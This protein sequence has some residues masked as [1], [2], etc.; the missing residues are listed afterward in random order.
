M[1][2]GGI[3][4]GNGE[5]LIGRGRQVAHPR[6]GKQPGRQGIRSHRQRIERGGA[7]EGPRDTVAGQGHRWRRV[8]GQTTGGDDHPAYLGRVGHRGRRRHQR[9]A[10]GDIDGIGGGAIGDA[11][12]RYGGGDQPVPTWREVRERHRGRK[13]PTEALGTGDVYGAG[14]ARGK[15]GKGHGQRTAGQLVAHREARGVAVQH[16]GINGGG[17]WRIAEAARQQRAGRDFPAARVR[18]GQQSRCRHGNVATARR[19]YGHRGADSTRCARDR[20]I[21]GGRQRP[22]ADRGR[23]RCG[24]AHDRHGERG[25]RGAE[26]PVGRT[27]GSHGDGVLTGGHVDPTHGTGR[28]ARERGADHG[29]IGLGAGGQSRHDEAQNTRR[30]RRGRGRRRQRH[31][32]SRR[33]ATD[34]GREQGQHTEPRKARGE[35]SHEPGVGGCVKDDSPRRTHQPREATGAF[36]H[37]L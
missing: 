7:T 25:R 16:E 34:A 8:G 27:H 1:N 36:D 21:D 18:R 20:E 17:R 29:D 14:K 35:S 33:I 5:V 22:V 12:S 10:H 9:G 6:H 11:A 3:P 4:G 30:N 37:A 15:T 24:S 2:R 28:G 19:R 31:R 32:A 13:R 23:S 26:G